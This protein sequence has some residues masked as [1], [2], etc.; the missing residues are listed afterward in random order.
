[1]AMPKSLETNASLSIC[2][3]KIIVRGKFTP[4]VIDVVMSRPK[5]PLDTAQPVKLIRLELP[6][7]G[8]ITCSR[9]TTTAYG[10]TLHNVTL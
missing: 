10:T 4:E 9:F 5:S 7:T 1:M 6:G 3:P 2:A 8:I